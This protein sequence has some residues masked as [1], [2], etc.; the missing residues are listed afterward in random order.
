MTVTTGRHGA[1]AHRHLGPRKEDP[2]APHRPGQLRRRHDRAGDGLDGARAQPVRARA[3]SAAST[4]R[5]R[6]RS[7]RRGRG[8]LRRR[9]RRRLGRAAA[10]GLARHRGHQ[11]P[12]ALAARDR[13]G[14]LRGRR[15]RRR[16]R[17]EPRAA[18]RTPRSSSRS[19]TS[20]CRRS[21]TSRRRSPTA[22]RSCT[23]SSARTTATRGRSPA[24]RRRPAVRRGRRHR[25]GALPPA[26][27]DPERDGA[28]RRAR[29][30]RSRP[31]ASCTMWSS[32]QIPHIARVTL[33]AVDRHPG[34]EA[35]RDRARRRRRLRL[36]AP[37]LRRRRR[38]RSCSRSARLPVKWIEERTENYLATHHGRDMIQEIELAATADGKITA[39]RVRLTASMGAYLQIITPGTP[40]LGAWVYGGCYD[41]EGYSFE[42]T[43]VFTNTT[44]TDAYRGAGRPEAT[45]AIERAMDALARKLG[46][47]PVELRRLNFISE[48]PDDARRRADDRLRRLRRRARP[49]ARDARLRGVPARAG[50]AR[51][52]GATPGSSGSASRPTSRCAGSRRRASSARSGTSRAAG[53][54]RRS[55]SCR[56][57]PCRSL[58]G[59][60]PHGQ[61]HDTTFA[62]IVA[63]RLGVG[64]DDVE[65]LHGDTAVAP[66]GM[67]TYGSRSLADRR[68][69][70]LQRRPRRSSRRRSGSPRTGSRWPRTTSTTR[71]ATFRVR[72]T[73]RTMTVKE[74][75]F[76]A[77]TAHDLPD[78]MEPALEATAV[79]DPAE[80]QLAGRHAHRRRRGRHRDRRGR[81]RPLRRGRR[82]RQR[83]STRRSSTARCTAGSRRASRRRSTRRRSTTRTAPC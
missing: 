40:L 11:Q 58:T 81:A 24:V 8:V 30:S 66:L 54:R 2:R 10:H 44:P 76:A 13:Q 39:V 25:Q 73:D 31:R 61:G 62:Q 57:G 15:R 59:T 12:D 70:A 53:R 32:T 49:G 4:S 22:R 36:E 3:R 42:C 28:A 48:F 6:S 50:G 23:T 29:R 34:G 37:G 45:Y 75:A 14:A 20:R 5:R 46:K 82:R 19:T 64:F 27:A 35:P 79:Y 7:G 55:A 9:S 18:R 80:L 68:R 78:G 16:G 17:R 65:V 67:D 43:G 52:S 47:D 71:P 72:G 41:V 1:D 83:R 38:S 74:A 33:V 69:R 77:W 63:D 56:P 26:A 21:P 60:S 51:A